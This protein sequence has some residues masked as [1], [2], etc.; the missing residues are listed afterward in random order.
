MN[1]PDLFSGLENMM[2][3][4]EDKAAKITEKFLEMDTTGDLMV[5]LFI[6]AVL[7]AVGEELFFRGL[8]QRIFSDWSRNKHV[9]IWVTA[10]V[11]SALHGQFYGFVPRMILGGMFG[12]LLVWSGSLWIP[13]LAHLVNNGVAVIASYYYQKG[14]LGFNPD[15][16]GTGPAELVFGLLSIILCA[17]ILYLLKKE[18]SKQEN[19]IES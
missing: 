19:T 1:L 6:I 5:N 9:G 14:M 8:L 7:P 12:Y 13:I 16:I 11:F 15:K 3:Q 17:G 10:V 18:F 4:L 2:R